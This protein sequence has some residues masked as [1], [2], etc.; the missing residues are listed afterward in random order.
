M[1]ESSMARRAQP[2]NLPSRAFKVID[3]CTFFNEL[4]LLRLRIK[5]LEDHVDHFVI[6]E[7]CETF[8]GQPKKPILIQENALDIASHPKVKIQTISLPHKETAWKREEFQRDKLIELAREIS[9]SPADIILLSDVDEIPAP[10]AIQE[11]IATL[12]KENHHTICIFEQRLFYFRLNYE[13]LYSRKMPWL[14]TSA[15]KIGHISSMSSLRATGRNLRGRKHRH[16]FDK[17]FRRRQIPNG[18]WHFSYLGGDDALAHKIRSFSHQESHIQAVSLSR[19]EAIMQ[20]R[21]SLFSTESH[22]EVWGVVSI[23]SV[24]LPIHRSE[25]PCDGYIIESGHT[26][27]P[28]VI[29]DVCRKSSLLKLRIGRFEIGIRRRTRPLR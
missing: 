23:E 17:K 20:H 21:A 1:T 24:G 7:A 8:T 6:V 25:L 15:S 28:D 27:I 5:C 10:I 26:P 18:G 19:V 13:L 12:A 22:H 4:E 3:C 9:T 14:G 2:A 11:A 29:R 16:L